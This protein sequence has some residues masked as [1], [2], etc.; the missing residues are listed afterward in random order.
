MQYASLFL[1]FPPPSP[2]NPHH[3]IFSCVL[4][5]VSS[6]AKKVRSFP[7]FFFSVPV[8]RGNFEQFQN[9]AMYVEAEFSNGIDSGG[10]GVRG[11][12]STRGAR[13]VLSETLA[14]TRE[15]GSGVGRVGS[16]GTSST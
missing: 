10:V 14:R 2:C 9:I 7:R 6:S 13:L 4:E 8:P 5:C 11:E 15:R 16:G 12:R 1:D 3:L